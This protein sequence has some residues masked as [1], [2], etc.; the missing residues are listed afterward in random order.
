[1]KKY[2]H[3]PFHTPDYEIISDCPK[4]LESLYLQYG[5]YISDV[6][7]ENPYRITVKKET[8]NNYIFEHIAGKSITD[9]PL[10]TFDDILFDTTTYDGSIIPL[11]GAAVEYNGNAYVFLAPTTSGKTTLTTYLT[12]NGCNYITEDCVL[13]DKQTFGVYPYPCPVHLR[14]GG[15][16]VLQKY[17]ITVP[18]VKILDTHAGLRYIYTPENCVKRLIPL[19]KIFFITRSET[20]NRITNMAVSENIMEL[21]KSGMTVYNPT[22]EHIRLMSKLAGTGCKALVYRDMEYVRDIII[23]GN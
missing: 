7:C 9:K 17:G 4:F 13:I 3:R 12:Y 20:E 21:M 16:E 15:V 22:A 23:K 10:L 18:N 6:E 11:H 19:G 5:G 8:N 1:M 2:L 14:T